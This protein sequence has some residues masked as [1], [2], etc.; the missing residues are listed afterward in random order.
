MSVVCVRS[1]ISCTRHCGFGGS[2]RMF[3]GDRYD[4]VP[5][6]ITFAKGVTSGYAPLGD[7]IASDALAEPFLAAGASFAHGIT[8]A[9]HPVS[10]AAA[11]V[12]D[13]P[14]TLEH[15]EIGE[16]GRAADRM[17]RE[18]DAVG[19]AGTRGEERFREGVAGDDAAQRRVAGGHAFGERDHVR[20]RSRIDLRRTSRRAARTRRSPRP[21]REARRSDH[22]SHARDGSSRVGAGS[23]HPCSAPVR[24]TPRRRCQVLPQRSP[25]R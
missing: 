11:D 22:R 18:R 3:A 16:R 19:E 21:T 24:G 23:I 5:D 14:F 10:C 4:Y 9:G 12:V 15:V 1:V 2:A 7:V 25:L 6:M 13:D 8:F 17:S 20:A